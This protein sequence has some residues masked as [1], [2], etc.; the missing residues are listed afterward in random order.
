MDS[1]WR[2]VLALYEESRFNDSEVTEECCRVRVAG[3]QPVMIPAWS[4]LVIQ[5]TVKRSRKSFTAVVEELCVTPPT[6]K[7]GLKLGPS[8]VTVDN[9]GYIPL[10]VANFT[11][12]DLYIQPRTPVGLLRAAVPESST[13]IVMAKENHCVKL[14][15]WF[16]RTTIP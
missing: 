6:L 12:Q 2:P 5:G 11:D 14:T 10:Q 13:H 7:N 8:L 16:I 15:V 3:K 9:S 1:K 4:V